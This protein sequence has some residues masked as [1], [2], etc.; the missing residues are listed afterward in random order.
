[1]FGGAFN[2]EN[3]D[4]LCIIQDSVFAENIG[5]IF[6]LSAGAGNTIMMKGNTEATLITKNILIIDSGITVRGFISK[7]LL[8]KLQF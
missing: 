3:W 4:S 7:Y 6:E 8:L 2:L 5:Y 1:M